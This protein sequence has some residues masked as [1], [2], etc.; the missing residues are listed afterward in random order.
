MSNV[1]TIA[2]PSDKTA[3]QVLSEIGKTVGKVEE[4][5]VY[6]V[7]IS[8]N[9]FT[10]KQDIKIEMAEETERNIKR[11]MPTMKRA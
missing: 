1:I 7:R 8:T 6:D 2:V 4:Y 11:S 5:A 3:K 9:A 10:G